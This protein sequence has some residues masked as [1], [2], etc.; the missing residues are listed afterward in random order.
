MNT[1]LKP[2]P[3]YK[4][5]GVEWISSVPSG[6]DIKPLKALFRPKK[7]LIGKDE[8]KYTLLRLSLNGVF[9]KQ[10]GQSGKN[11]ANY[12]AYQLYS[13]GDLVFCTFDYD[14]TPRTIGLVQEPGILTGAYTRLVPKPEVSSKYYYYFY[15]VLDTNKELLHLCTGLRHGLSKFVFWAL[16]NPVPPLETQKSIAAFLDER[17][18][19]IDELI[20]KK[21]RLMELLREKRQS[22]IIRVVTKGLDPK[23]KM[24]ASG[25]EW[26]GDI[27]KEWKILPFR[28]LFREKNISNESG[29]VQ[30]VLSL[31]Y[32]RI[33]DRDV[34]SNFGLLPAS[35]D[36]YQ[37]IEAGWIVFR[38]TDL[39]NDHKSLRTALATKRGI[40]TS[41][42]L[43]VE[44][45]HQVRPAYASYLLHAYDLC[46]VFYSMGGGIRQSID[47]V[48]LK[49]MPIPLPSIEEQ[50]A[51]IQHVDKE[52]M[53]IDKAATLIA[54]Q[55]EQLKE[56]R[57]SL[58][59][60]SVTGK[61]KV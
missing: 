23:A 49:W 14:V 24:K 17:T 26:V 54:S 28:S 2:Y 29:S 8:E 38:L 56:Y 11:P 21:E 51:I 59:Y 58:I 7:E 12:E 43:A 27:P 44:A 36:T 41:A 25:M 42:Y 33:V 32:G 53:K 60:S 47:Y 52:A 19:V 13:P 30:N 15:L 37:I 50:D 40:I 4:D 55:L 6:W 10:E 20:A 5:S 3:K 35:F 45:M 9:P 22:L 39:Q 16:P 61:I 48:D 1:S 18:K 34:E 57:A 46:K 31:S